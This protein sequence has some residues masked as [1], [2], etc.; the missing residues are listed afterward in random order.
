M[1]KVAA[2]LCGGPGTRIR[3][4][5]PGL[6]KC[7][8]PVDGVPFI[9]P[10]AR[11]LRSEG[12]SSLIVMGGHH[13]EQLRQFF[14][15][16]GWSNVALFV[17]STGNAHAVLTALRH[18][19]DLKAEN[20]VILNGDTVLDISYEIVYEYH[21][22]HNSDIT[23]VTSTKAG[24]KGGIVEIESSTKRVLAFNEGLGVTTPNRHINCGCYIFRINACLPHFR[25]EWLSLEFEAFPFL[26][27]LV[28][29][30]AYSNGDRF[31]VDFGTP[32]GLATMRNNMDQV[33]QALTKSWRDRSQ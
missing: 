31:F 15:E 28:N 9:I 21:Q 26:L 4:F 33:N 19:A 27:S 14:A 8:V 17:D 18:S 20:I 1:T 23:I 6:P 2:I 29:V 30:I 3:G 25:D 5:F 32:D 16:V 22:T 10:L 24:C 11:K 13:V 7:L 12:F